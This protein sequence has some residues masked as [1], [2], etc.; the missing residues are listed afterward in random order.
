VAND[1][2]NA[3][4]TAQFAEILSLKFEMT[5]CLFVTQSGLSHLLFEWYPMETPE[6]SP[7]D[8]CQDIAIPGSE[9]GMHRFCTNNL[10]TLS[11]IC[12]CVRR[13]PSD[14]DIASGL[15]A[16]RLMCVSENVPR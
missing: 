4:H 11:Q 6:K 14:G 16:I 5:D 1:Q 9:P 2:P 10:T 3:A 12:E 15:W 7:R 8:V 13:R